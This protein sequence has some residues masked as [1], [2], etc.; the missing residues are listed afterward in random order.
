[1]Q[2]PHL[3]FRALCPTLYPA[4]YLIIFLRFEK[5][6]PQGVYV[7]WFKMFPPLCCLPLFIV[8]ERFMLKSFF[9]REQW[10]NY[11]LFSNNY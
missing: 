6:T 9:L 5:D 1:M 7:L 4:R 10:K 8:M 2:T 11:C 3:V